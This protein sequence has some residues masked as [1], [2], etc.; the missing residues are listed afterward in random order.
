PQEQS[1]A[2]IPDSRHNHWMPTPHD[3]HVFVFLHHL[4]WNTPPLRVG[5]LHAVVRLL[6]CSRQWECH[7]VHTLAASL[8]RGR[9]HAAMGEN[10]SDEHDGQ[11]A[12]SFPPMKG[13]PGQHR[14][15][16]PPTGLR[17]AQACGLSAWLHDP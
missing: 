7:A 8:E 4:G 17:C 1:V 15:T 6:Y 5:L 2:T 10:V 16:I 13:G 14:P 3:G 9:S 12:Y 11:Y